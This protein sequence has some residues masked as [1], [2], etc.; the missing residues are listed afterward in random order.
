M[1][2][3]LYTILSLFLVGLVLSSLKTK[4]FR[5][6]ITEERAHELKFE[7]TWYKFL[8]NPFYGIWIVFLGFFEVLRIGLVV[9]AEFTHAVFHVVKSVYS[10]VF[11]D[12]RSF[13]QAYNFVLTNHKN[14][15]KSDLENIAKAYNVPMNHLLRL[16]LSP[17]FSTLTAIVKERAKFPD[18]SG[19]QLDQLL[20]T[21][22]G[23]GIDYLKNSSSKTKEE[24]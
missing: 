7:V 12:H 18:L 11:T 14:L 2:I 15:K 19:E 17:T 6:A 23:L 5:S 21:I 13:S 8:K 24:M 4:K 1:T 3:A 9:F 20:N 16:T 10:T 22:D